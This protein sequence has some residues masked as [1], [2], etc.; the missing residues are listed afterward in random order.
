MKA[1]K[2]DHDVGW[3]GDD[4]LRRSLPVHCPVPQQELQESRS[5][6]R[7]HQPRG[8]R[9]REPAVQSSGHARRRVDSVAKGP[10]PVGSRCRDRCRGRPV[11]PRRVLRWTDGRRQADNEDGG[12]ALSA[13]EPVQDQGADQAARLPRPEPEPTRHRAAQQRSRHRSAVRRGSQAPDEVG[14]PIRR[15]PMTTEIAVIQ[16][17]ASKRILPQPRSGAD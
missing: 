14:E 5:A 1:R 12:I 2:V 8:L 15:R 13:E 6:S 10:M 7:C 16:T 9:R 17:R 4:D 11:R 3:V